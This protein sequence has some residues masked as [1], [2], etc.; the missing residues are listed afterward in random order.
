METE[1]FFSGYCR[2]QD[3]SRMVTAVVTDGRLEEADCGFGSCPYEDSCR[4]G[5]R[6]AELQ[7]GSGEK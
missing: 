4:I 3:Q 6:L 2:R 5:Q 7:N 1:L